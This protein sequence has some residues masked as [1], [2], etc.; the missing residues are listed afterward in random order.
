MLTDRAM[1]DLIALF[2]ARADAAVRE[3]FDQPED[4]CHRAVADTWQ[5]AVRLL[6]L[7]I[8]PTGSV[9]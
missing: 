9:D 8:R 2:Q 5:Q 1:M 7:T 4:P 3:A 6:H